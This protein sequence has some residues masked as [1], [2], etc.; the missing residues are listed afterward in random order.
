MNFYFKSCLLSLFL[1]LTA[2][3]L[4]YGIGIGSYNSTVCREQYQISVEPSEY[5]CRLLGFP[6]SYIEN[7]IWGH[8]AHVYSL[9]FVLNLVFWSVACYP[10]LILLRRYLKNA[11]EAVSTTIKATRSAIL[12]E[13]FAVPLIL[14]IFV[15]DLPVRQGDLRDIYFRLVN[16]WSA[17]YVPIPIITFLGILLGT[18][19]LFHKSRTRHNY[20]ATEERSLRQI[21]L[22][23]P[24]LIAAWNIIAMMFVAWIPEVV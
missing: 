6:I 4:I 3:M 5:G 7:D 13:L 22:Y 19:G 16:R 1:G 23:L 8:N 12:L 21:V 18:A 24:F 15:S 9:E 20:G 14:L 17:L 11:F 2:V 10:L